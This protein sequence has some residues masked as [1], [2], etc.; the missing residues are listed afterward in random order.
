MFKT[1]LLV[2]AGAC[3]LSAF[4]A[5][6][7]YLPFAPPIALIAAACAI[8]LVLAVLAGARRLAVAACAVLASASLAGCNGLPGTGGGQNFD[9]NKFLTDPACAHDDKIQGVTGAAGI[10]ASLQFSAERHCPGTSAT[11][12]P[13]LAVGT[14]VAPPTPPAGR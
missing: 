9:L 12:A 14:V 11:A 2:I 5:A 13:P 3:L 10:P 1:F 7:G 6:L 8:L 4:A